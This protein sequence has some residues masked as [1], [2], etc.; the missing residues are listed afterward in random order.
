MAVT[1]EQIERCVTTINESVDEL[2]E[3]LNR[4]KYNNWMTVKEGKLWVLHNKMG[5]LIISY[6]NAKARCE[7]LMEPADE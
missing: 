7:K 2:I 5:Q 3:I 4:D 6:Q 1:S